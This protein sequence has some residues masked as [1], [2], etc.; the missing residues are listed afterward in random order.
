MKRSDEPAFNRETIRNM[1]DLSF[2]TH[3][4]IFDDLLIVAQKETNC[5]VLKSSG[6]LIVIDAIW[7]AREAFEAIVDA[8]KAVGWDPETIRKLILTHGHVD[9]TGC[10]RWFV[11]RYHAETYLSEVD[12][13]FWREHP[14]KPDGPETW[15]DYQIDHYL[16]DCDTVTLGDKTIYAYL[17]PGHTPGCLSYMFRYGKRRTPHGG[18]VGRYDAAVDQAGGAAVSAVS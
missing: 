1:E 4:L 14:T 7:P 8:V 17:T 12:D 2:F 16:R 18:F 10:G 9:H 5:F 13:R 6:G 11:E 15:K 3:A